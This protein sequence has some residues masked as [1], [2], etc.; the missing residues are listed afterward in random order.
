MR[1]E[2]PEMRI[3]DKGVWYDGKQIG[4]LNGENSDEENTVLV[5]HF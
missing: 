2:K 4:K 5:K 3:N 1:K